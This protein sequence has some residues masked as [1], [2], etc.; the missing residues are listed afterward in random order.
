MS[1][2]NQSKGIKRLLNTLAYSRDGL[3]VALK[4]AAIVQLIMLH[5]PL[6]G[7]ALWLDVGVAVKMVLVLVS[8]LSLIVEFIN[9]AIE[10]AV[11]HT[12]MQ[13]HPLAKIA[14][15]VGSAAQ[16]VSL[17]LVAIMWAMAWFG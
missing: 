1:A 13:L 5:T 11:D 6:I 2:F 8:F 12:S 15:D 7:L 10:A 16:L 9:T 3:K 14:K 17:M 4:E